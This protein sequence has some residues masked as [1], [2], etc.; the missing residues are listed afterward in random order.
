MNHEANM[1]HALN[2]ARKALDEDEFPVGCAVL[3]DGRV[4]AAARRVNSRRSVPSEL[5]HAEIIALRQ[6]EALDGALDRRRMVLYATL[7]PCLM[8]FGAI[9][10]SGI[11]TLVYAYEDAMGG[12]T[13]CDRARLPSLYR[14]SPIQIVSGVCR[15][16]SLALFQAFYRRPHIGY[17]RDSLLERY[18]LD[19]G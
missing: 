9:L 11:G 13:A 17:W 10:I 3:L 14:D 2:E 4:L 1:R 6:V 5:D 18:T 16:E 7:E 15:Q 8:C 19:Q 12:G